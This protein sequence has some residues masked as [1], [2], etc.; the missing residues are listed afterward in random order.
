MVLKSCRRR[1]LP[2]LSLFWIL[3]WWTKWPYGRSRPCSGRRTRTSSRRPSWSYC[4]S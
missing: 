4:R 1:L 2:P 3:T